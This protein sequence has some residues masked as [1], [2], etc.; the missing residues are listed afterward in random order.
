WRRW[1]SF[2]STG[3]GSRTRSWTSSWITL[4]DSGRRPGS[5]R[6]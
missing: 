3:S 5:S 4:T 6:R 2:D 1:M